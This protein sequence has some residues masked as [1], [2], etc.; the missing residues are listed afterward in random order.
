[1]KK[2]KTAPIHQSLIA[3]PTL[4]I[5]PPIIGESASQAMHLPVSPGGPEFVKSLT[6]SMT[7]DRR[8]QKK[9]QEPTL[10]LS[11]PKSVGA[12]PGVSPLIL[13]PDAKRTQQKV[14][15]AP[16]TSTDGAKIAGGKK[17]S[18]G[19]SFSKIAIL[20]SFFERKAAQEAGLIPPTQPHQRLFPWSGGKD[21]K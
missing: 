11:G 7:L 15:S 8:S 14:K 9:K 3:P 2:T 10:G 13:I 20:S 12:V 19:P 5:T 6:V 1:M 21:R 4:I 17:K 16:L 18:S